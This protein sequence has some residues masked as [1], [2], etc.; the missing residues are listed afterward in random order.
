MNLKNLLIL[1]FCASTYAQQVEVSGTIISSDDNMPIVGANI[2]L[3]EGGS[4]T[5]SD[6]DGNYQISVKKG[7]ILQFSYIGFQTQEI[8]I[9]NQMLIMISL[10]PNPEALDEVIV[11][12]GYGTQRKKEITGAVSV[13]DSKAIEKLN[14]IRI[15]QALQGQVSGVNI[16]SASGSPG[17]SLNIRIRG[18]STN[19]DSRPLILVDGN[20]IED[21]SVINPNDIK[22]LNVLK[23]ATAGIYGVQAANG[24]ILIET[25]TGRKNSK[26]KVSLDTYI[27]F[28]TTSKKIDLIND[29]Y[30]YASYVND[31]SRNGR[32]QDKFIPIQTT[33]LVFELNDFINP[34][35]TNTDWQDAVFDQAPIHNTNIS[36]NGGTEKLSYSFG[37]S[38]IDQKGIVGLDKSG[39]QRTTTRLS[40]QYALL[41]N[42]NLTM[43]GIYTN[44]TKNNLSEGGIGSVLYSA[45]NIDPFTTVRST[46]P[47]SNG[48]GEPLVSAREV[49]NPV[50]I[51]ENTYNKTR[52]DKISGTFGIDYTIIEWLKFDTK[53]QFNH[54][55]VLSDVFLPVF[56]YGSGKQGTVEDDPDVIKDDGN[57]LTD[58]A[59]F[60]D[61]FKWENYITYDNVFNEAHYL[62]VLLGTSILE[63][64]GL[65]TGRSGRGLIN[66][67]NT[68]ED[69]LFAYVPPENIRSRFNDDQLEA[70]ADRFIT[71]LLSVFSRIQYN[72]KG[73]YL[74][75]AVI[76]RDGSSK[77]GPANRFGY[78][79]SG[80]IGWN[81][82]EED[83]FKDNQV[84]NSLKFRASYGTL[85]NDRIALNRFIS[86]LDGQALYTNN[87][88]TDAD[89]VLIGKAIGGLA[90]PEI[91]WEGTKSTNIGIDM[92]FFNDDLSIS[93]DVF[94][95]RTEDL[96]VQANVSGILG[97]AAPGSSAPI[98]NAGDVENKG[99]EFLA[100]YNKN[101]SN[102][103][104]F[105]LSYNLSTL[106]NEVIYVGS[107]EGFL[108]G[109]SFL[110]GENL[111]TSRMEAG[112]PIGY[113]YGYKTNGIYQDQAEINFLN[114][115]APLA[116][117]GDIG[118][119]HK[120][121]KPGDLKFVDVNDDGQ[122]T[123][124]DKTYIGDPIPELTMGV[125]LGFNYKN[126]DFNTS[127]FASIGNDM[128]R[129]YERKN[130]YS[131][132]GTYVLDRWT[133][134]NS[135]NTVPRA[136][137]G[138]SIS[139][140]NFSDYFVE[141]A[142]Y[143]R[144]QNIQIGY[145]F[146][147][148]IINK[149]GVSRFRIYASG[150]NLFTF[151]DYSGY[152]P[153]AVG[154]GGP[155]GSGIDKGFY[156]VA[157]TFLL[158]MNLNF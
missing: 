70:G 65:F 128:V 104:R 83:F 91:K 129:D 124:E 24:V 116:A 35:T 143:V 16:T 108:Q 10:S 117:N 43:T 123:V 37:A 66:N 42:L 8:L 26:L 72:Y 56:D 4:G 140:D 52:I 114:V 75:S 152:D 5:T 3:K 118:E 113:F 19:G 79:P 136:V 74:L 122:I 53:F 146:S 49:V 7:D 30:D 6:F 134:T 59:D 2:L 61:D 82:S 111:L 67:R 132:K 69:A 99:F 27:G 14:P 1:F 47:N 40:L 9:E 109:G 32:G 20:I 31:A 153:S 86:L 46:D 11:T 92:K 121:A 36:F 141:D 155:I 106:H 142:S 88:E 62:T 21:L 12:V 13:L 115:N 139:F 87:D 156:P 41:R 29:I 130:L 44:S 135:S 145:T 148:E 34:L 33:R 137:N 22:S 105:N 158:G 17:S 63:T 64:R 45:L 125:N 133:P 55:A 15:E 138:S 23:D 96:L 112:F 126:I 131:N 57:S 60:Y 149:I 18:I 68:I 76:R 80:S 150:N 110:V 147:E 90:N 38:L 48:Y 100:S 101:L 81:V 98:I 78:F 102:D 157:K 103:F 58:N 151:T 73:K 120:D 85:G 51:I 54:A 95:K 28:Q 84:F 89:D 119:Y 94:S 39:Y 97:A 154:G 93:A 127:A 50:A 107:T 71:R 25:K 77:F 144:V